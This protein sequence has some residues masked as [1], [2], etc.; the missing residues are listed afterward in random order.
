MIRD[1]QEDE[2]PVEVV[3]VTTSFWKD[4]RGVYMRK[5]IIQQHRKSCG[6][7]TMND[8]CDMI[9]ADETI[10]RIKNLLSV[11]DGLYKIVL[12]NISKDWE[13]GYVDSYDYE[14]IPYTP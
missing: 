8:D 7:Q 1:T 11:K 2:S 13:T 4:S 3:R 5:N 10:T 6:H 9:G 12:T 14:L